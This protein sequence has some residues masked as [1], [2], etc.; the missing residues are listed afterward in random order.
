LRVCCPRFLTSGRSAAGANGG[1]GVL[2][3]V[4]EELPR[5]GGR[6]AGPLDPHQPG[7]GGV[8]PPLGARS[9]FMTPAGVIMALRA[10]PVGLLIVGSAYGGMAGI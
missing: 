5:C 6:L 3:T 1:Q 9:S 4:A 8:Q 2:V 10:V 7:E